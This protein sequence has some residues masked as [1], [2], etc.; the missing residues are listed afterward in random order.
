MKEYQAG[1]QT[2]QKSVKNDQ[3]PAR[4]V[5]RRHLIHDDTFIVYLLCIPAFCDLYRRYRSSLSYRFDIHAHNT[6]FCRDVPDLYY[7]FFFKHHIYVFRPYIIDTASVIQR[8][9]IAVNCDENSGK[10]CKDSEKDKDPVSAPRYDLPSTGFLTV[11]PV[12]SE[13]FPDSFQYPVQL[14]QPPSRHKDM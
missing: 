5:L 4:E 10:R 12:I 1:P 14:R 9:V 3:L 11:R 7:P 2:D 6:V 8:D 13:D